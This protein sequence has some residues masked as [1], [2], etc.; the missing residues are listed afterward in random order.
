MPLAALLERDAAGNAIQGHVV[1][2][3]TTHSIIISDDG[4][5]VATLGV[6]DL[7]VVHS[8]QGDAGRPQGPARQ[9]EGPGR[10][11]GRRG[12]RNLSLIDICSRNGMRI[13]TRVR[14]EM[15]REP[16]C[17]ISRRPDREWLIPVPAAALTCNQ[18][19]A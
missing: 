8:G 10:G 7:V 3:D 5:L 13:A 1:T 9:A 16:P 12:A 2:R 4:G 14:D 18:K 6:D 19:V 15:V 17:P 11:V